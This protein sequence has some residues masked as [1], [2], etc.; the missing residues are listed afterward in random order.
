MLNEQRFNIHLNKFNENNNLYR[1][2]YDFTLFR[3][4]HAGYFFIFER[5]KW[6]PIALGAW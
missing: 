6:N 1:P 4:Y 5:P 2:L 3:L